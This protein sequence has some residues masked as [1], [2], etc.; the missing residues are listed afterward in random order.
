MALTEAS[1][2]FATERKAK[3][4]V[5]KS[6]GK[7]WDLSTI[8]GQV[9]LKPGHRSR[10]PRP[11]ASQAAKRAILSARKSSGVGIRLFVLVQPSMGANCPGLPCTDVAIL[12]P[13]RAASQTENG[14]DFTL[15][16]LDSRHLAGSSSTTTVT[17]L[18]LRRDNSFPPLEALWLTSFSK[19]FLCFSMFYAAR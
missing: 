5:R 1:R 19:Y 10:R 9:G 6:H 3:M 8:D 4:Q 2:G 11:S 15:Q 16:V 14:S 17:H 7:N 18:L 12:E 13:W